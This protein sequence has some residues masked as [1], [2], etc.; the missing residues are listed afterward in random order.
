MVVRFSHLSQTINSDKC[1]INLIDKK[2]QVKISEY[3]EFCVLFD[4]NINN[5]RLLY[6][7][8]NAK[9]QIQ[10]SVWKD[11]CMQKLSKPAW[12]AAIIFN[13]NRT[14]HFEYFE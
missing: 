5:Y 12:I 6:L 13:I 9:I 2:K 7:I 14:F 10:D 3:Y 4:K 1:I 11:D 8:E